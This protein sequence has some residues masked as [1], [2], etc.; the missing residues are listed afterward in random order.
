MHYRQP[1]LC[2]LLGL[3]G[4]FSSDP[5]I[6]ATDPEAHYRLDETTGTT[7]VDASGNGNDGTYVNGPTLGVAGIRGNAV[8]L[9]MVGTDDR[10]DLPNTVLDG[11]LDASFAFW[12]KTTR[13]GS[14]SVLSGANAV[15]DNEFSIL[16]STNTSLGFLRGT[17]EVFIPIPSVADDQWHHFV[18]A[19]D[20][21]AGRVFLYLD[22]QLF[23]D[24]GMGLAGVLIDIDPGGLL[25]GQEQD[26]LG[27]CFSS[28]QIVAGSLD[29]VRIYRRVL[30]DEEVAILYN[31][32][33]GHWKLD[34][35]AGTVAADSSGIGNDATHTG[36]VIVNAMGPYPGTGDVAAEFDGIDDQSETASPFDPPATG[37]V[38][39]WMRGAATPLVRQH[40][41]GV[42]G[43]W[44]VRQE[45]DGTLKFD[46]GASPAVGSELFST[47]EA[48]DVD[49][50]WYHVVAN[51]NDAN[52]TYE[53]YVNGQ[54]QASGVS[55]V[56]LI[57]Q[58]AGILSIGTRTGIS[59]NWKGALFDLRIYNH[60]LTHRQ[61]AELYGLVGWWKLDETSGSVAT[62]SSGTDLHGTYI[63]TPM[64]GE[65]SRAPALG[66][67]VDFD[68][69]A[70]Y[71]DLPDAQ[72]DFSNGIAITS[73]M[74]PAAAPSPEFAMFGMSNGVDTDEIWFGWSLG[75]GAM[76][77]F[78]DTADGSTWRSLYDSE[79]PTVGLWQHCILSIDYLGN[80]TLYRDGEA[81]ASGFT[82]LP[83]S[84]IRSDNFI[85]K[86]V[87]DDEFPGTLDDVRLYHRPISS[88][89]ARLLFD[90]GRRGLRID[91][92]VE[93]R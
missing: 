33:V 52:D 39:F 76:G 1:I 32:L 86:S 61:V 45:T 71:I 26:C 70:E 28:G 87:Q 9:N 42:N 8:Q 27:G 20:G 78:S 13:T 75:F 2:L 29:D 50:Q 37:A 17:N 89:E 65:S 68:G 23:G 91:T 11:A 81:I 59:E 35:T 57:S 38:A 12:I 30:S 48:L 25:L 7:A 77:Y 60:E 19:W 55:P 5:S 64:L 18:F 62:D 72:F 47:T 66:T 54:L 69:I 90:A 3:L 15:R 16:F 41:F 31:G 14:S 85:A 46:L 6:A 34:E 67:S 83:T 80:A 22:G 21:N 4:F 74:K 44:E 49:G 36:G 84:L 93:T 73:W 58:S 51:F 63:S 56:D 88:D 24:Y 82:S 53:V 43:D 40:L 10:I 79:E 92:W